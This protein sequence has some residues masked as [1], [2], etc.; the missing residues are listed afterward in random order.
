[1]AC[2]KEFITALKPP[3]AMPFSIS[4]AVSTSFS[5]VF[6]P[7]NN[8]AAPPIIPS[9]TVSVIIVSSAPSSNSVGFR[10]SGAFPVLTR[11]PA[12]AARAKPVSTRISRAGD[13]TGI[14]G[15]RHAFM[16]PEVYH[17]TTH[18]MLLEFIREAQHVFKSK[19]GTYQHDHPHLHEWQKIHHTEI[20]YFFLVFES[21]HEYMR[22]SES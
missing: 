20:S 2:L 19:L 21:E 1:M 16:V 12:I 8:A 18:K 14:L 9:K 6:I 13:K 17:G 22:S 15:S 10:P 3:A 4:A 5:N 7:P 11:Y